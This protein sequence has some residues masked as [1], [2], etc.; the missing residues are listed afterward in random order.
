MKSIYYWS[1]CLTRIGTYT[2]TINSAV[3]IARYSK[4]QYSVKIINICGEWDSDARLS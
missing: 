4:D 3:S 2:S 1:P